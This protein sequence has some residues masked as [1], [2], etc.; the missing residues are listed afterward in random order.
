MSD[1]TKELYDS[2]PGESK[3]DFF[4]AYVYMKYIDH[5]MYHAIQ[6]SGLPAKEPEEK[7]SE[8]LKHG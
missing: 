6:A 4:S 7:L 8:V 3:G 5:F 2:Y 1:S